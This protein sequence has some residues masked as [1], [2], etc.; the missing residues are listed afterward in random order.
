MICPNCNST[1]WE[2]AD[3]FRTKPAEMAICKCCGFV[4]YPAKYQNKEAVIE[5]YRHEYRSAPTTHNIYTGERKNHFHLKNLNSI[6]EQWK[7]DG[8][9]NPKILEVGA[10]FGFTLQWIKQ[11]FPKAELNGTELTQSFRRV[12]KHEFG[13]TL[14]EDIDDT[15]KYDLIISYKVLEHQCDPH[16]EL[17]R[18][19]KMLTPNG[20]FYISVPTW[21]SS[22]Y[23]FGVPGFDLE[24]WYDPNHI[25]VWTRE[26]FENLLARN[27]F[28]ILVNDQITYSSTYVCK[29][30]PDMVKPDV[31]KHDYQQMKTM[32]GKI[33]MAYNLLAENKFDEAIAIWPDYPQAHAT[34]AEFMRKKLATEG[35]DWFREN[36]V[37]YAIKCCPNS[38]EILVLATDYAMRAKQFK[39]ALKYAERSL[40]AKPEN[41]IS[42]HHMANCCRELAITSTNPKDQINWFMQGREVCGHLRMVSTQYFK[43]ATDLLFFFSAQIPFRGENKRVDRSPIVAEK[44][45]PEISI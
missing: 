33:K 19:A 20:R 18:Y 16:L 31:F 21:F 29:H 27:G 12:A 26:I 23:N 35:W 14:D 17:A 22:L 4:S 5:H 32:M 45:E 25:N 9:E 38:S 42:L 43:D 44:R 39:I 7:R 40:K 3:E 8:L 24:Y 41:P 1:D 28:E 10:A 13:I 6:F 30:N 2:N 15:K 37:E 11:M 34:R 36:V